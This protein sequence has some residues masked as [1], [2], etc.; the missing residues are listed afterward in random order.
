MKLARQHFL[1]LSPPQPQRV[2]FIARQGSY[3]GNTLGA[4]GVSGHKARRS[5]YEPMLSPNVSHVSGCNLYRGLNENETVEAYV[6]RLAE[7]LDLE[8]QRVSPETVCGFVAE[9]VVGAVSSSS[10][11]ELQTPV[12]P[13]L[14]IK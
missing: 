1:E 12:D 4:L 8:F 7:E 2:R 10:S 3:H 9:P 14:I 5:I 13:T 11:L 6:E